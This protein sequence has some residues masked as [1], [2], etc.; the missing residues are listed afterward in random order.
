MN[1]GKDPQIPG[2][3]VFTSIPLKPT[4]YGTFPGLVITN[5]MFT[6]GY[7]KTTSTLMTIA[8][9]GR[10]FGVESEGSIESK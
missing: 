8:K 4:H 10:S 9:G 6:K 1:A 2:A 5:T 3:P 7:G